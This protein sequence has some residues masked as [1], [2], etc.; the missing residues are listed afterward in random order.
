MVP[1]GKRCGKVLLNLV[2]WRDLEPRSGL[3]VRRP[4]HSL[5]HF[6]ASSRS[7]STSRTMA[8]VSRS[9]GGVGAIAHADCGWEA[10]RGGDSPLQGRDVQ[11][12]PH[13]PGDLLASWRR[14]G[15]AVT[16]SSGV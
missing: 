1:S 9:P 13:T 12:Q 16:S 7:R 5:A 10:A 14:G 4:E 15:V 8:H 2:C 11:R 3:A 6:A